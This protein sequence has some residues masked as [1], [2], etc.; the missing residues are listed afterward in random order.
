[1]IVAVV[2]ILSHEL[3]CTQLKNLI[4]LHTDLKVLALP[5]HKQDS[6]PFH[7]QVLLLNDD[8]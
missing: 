6:L 8:K 5:L 4:R 2:D 1:M 7:L 3:S